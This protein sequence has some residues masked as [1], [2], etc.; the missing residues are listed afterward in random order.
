MHGGNLFVSISKVTV[1][2]TKTPIRF[3]KTCLLTR[4]GN[5]ATVMAWWHCRNIAE[6]LSSHLSE[7]IHVVWNLLQWML[8]IM[9]AHSLALACYWSPRF[10]DS[11]EKK[12]GVGLSVI[13]NT[14]T[15][16]ISRLEAEGTIGC[17][18]ASE[19]PSEFEWHWSIMEP[20]LQVN[21]FCGFV[22]RVE[23]CI[24]ERLRNSRIEVVAPPGACRRE[25][26][27]YRFVHVEWTFADQHPRWLTGV[28]RP[29]IRNKTHC[30]KHLDPGGN[31]RLYVFV[32]EDPAF[33]SAGNDS[34]LRLAIANVWWNHVRIHDEALG[35][36]TELWISGVVYLLWID[37]TM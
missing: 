21:V 34:H 26:R 27:L 13:L 9:L 16:K 22:V 35:C 5:V 24:A 7:H 20:S 30:R 8:S 10:P 28:S 36:P 2:Y 32:R 15:L 14:S 17:C 11:P 23:T 3:L 37:Q 29:D 18:R 25:A 6:I 1:V 19:D 4:R 12:S 31:Y 33:C